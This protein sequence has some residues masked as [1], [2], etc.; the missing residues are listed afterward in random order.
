[1]L[2]HCPDAKSKVH[3]KY[4]Q[5]I[6]WKNTKTTKSQLANKTSL[7]AENTLLKYEIF[8]VSGRLEHF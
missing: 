5:V 7:R 3:P 1:M 6:Y 4:V 2:V 8:P